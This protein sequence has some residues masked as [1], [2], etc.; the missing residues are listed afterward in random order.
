[1]EGPAIKKVC[2]EQAREG[3]RPALMHVAQAP[4]DQSHNDNQRLGMQ[5]LSALFAPRT[6]TIVL[7]IEGVSSANVWANGPS[8]SGGRGRRS[9]A[10]CL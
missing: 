9:I 10:R 7:H 3:G 1:M 6:I 4:M 2:R 8:R 5:R